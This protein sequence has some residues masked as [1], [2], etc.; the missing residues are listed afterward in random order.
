MRSVVLSCPH[1]IATTYDYIICAHKAISP[2]LDPND[3]R[4]VANMDTTFVILQN[5]V[6]NE[7]PF[8]NAFPYCSIVSCVV[9][10]TLLFSLSLIEEGM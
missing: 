10:Y 5:G 8:R 2:G 4:S 6:G 1:K 7:E 3:F 9:S